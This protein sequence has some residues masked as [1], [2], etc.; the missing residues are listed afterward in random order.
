MKKSLSLVIAAALLLAGAWWL[1]RDARER[2]TTSAR[3]G[4][5]MAPEVREAVTPHTAAANS[6]EKNQQEMHTEVAASA[7]APAPDWGRRL[8]ESDDFWAFA[9]SAIGPA[10]RGDGDARFWLAIALNECEFMYPM[11]FIDDPPGKRPRHLTLDEAQQRNAGQRSLYSADDITLL[12]KRCT[13]LSQ[14]KDS[15]FGNGREWM[16]AALAVDHPIALAA[17]AAMK[18]LMSLHISGSGAGPRGAGG[19]PKAECRSGTHG[20]A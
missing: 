2:G 17:K 15:P 9:E 5:A 7:D 4:S 12:E 10:N 8:E 6:I 14:A 11:F 18:S 13:R 16:D 19:S 1:V 20:H 3:S